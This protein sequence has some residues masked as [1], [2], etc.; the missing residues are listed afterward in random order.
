MGYPLSCTIL[1]IL[2]RVYTRSIFL[3]ARTTPV[4]GMNSRSGFLTMTP[5]DVIW[6][7]F[8]GRMASYVQRADIK[9][10]GGVPAICGSA[11]SVVAEHRSRQA[12][13]W[14]RREHLSKYGLPLLGTSPTR[15]SG[16]VRLVFNVC[17]DSGV[18]KPL[19]RCCTSFGRR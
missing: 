12:P 5:V 4:V 11:R 10:H 13:F 16:S 6:R 8:V 9:K 14:T 1:N 18:N 3:Q 7:G 17:W 19:G 15:N 2:W